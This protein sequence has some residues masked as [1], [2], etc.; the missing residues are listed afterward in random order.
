MKFQ[1]LYLAQKFSVNESKLI[2]LIN[3]CKF[4]GVPSLFFNWPHYISTFSITSVTLH[5]NQCVSRQFSKYI[6]DI[7]HHTYLQI[8]S[9]VC[10]WDRGSQCVVCGLMAH[11]WQNWKRVFLTCPCHEI[12]KDEAVGLKSCKCTWKIT[13]YMNMWNLGQFW[14]FDILSITA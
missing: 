3:N 13:I 9:Y 10:N 7:C 14:Y 1:S 2:I 5:T 8:T 6:A 11:N 12:Y 4:S